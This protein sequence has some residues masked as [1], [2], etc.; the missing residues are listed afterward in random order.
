[1]GLQRLLCML[2]KKVTEDF[3]TIVEATF[4]RYMAGDTSISSKLT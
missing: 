2:D 3:R 1:M 4:A